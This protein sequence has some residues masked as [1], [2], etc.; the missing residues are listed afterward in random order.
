MYIFV[1]FVILNDN[2]RD[3]LMELSDDYFAS[4]SSHF[5]VPPLLSVFCWESWEIYCTSEGN[6]HCVH[7][8]RGW[9]Y[10]IL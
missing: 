10:F 7:F 8:F 1:L 5:I 3:A 4:S 2:C 9:G 6:M